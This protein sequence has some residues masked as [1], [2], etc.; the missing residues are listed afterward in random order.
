MQLNPYLDED[1]IV[2]V[3][4]RI[5]RAA[6]SNLRRHQMMLSGRHYLFNLLAKSFHDKTHNGK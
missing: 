4:G 1:S 2:R 3:G 6:I 5:D